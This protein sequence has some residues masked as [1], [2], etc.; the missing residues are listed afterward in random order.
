MQP[1]RVTETARNADS[2]CISPKTGTPAPATKAALKSSPEEKERES[3]REKDISWED[4]VTNCK[5]WWTDAVIRKEI[6]Q[7]TADY[8]SF[9]MPALTAYFSGKTLLTI[10]KTDLIDY[11]TARIKAAKSPVTV[12]HEIKALRRM[13]TMHLARTTAEECPRLSAKA[14]DIGRVDLLK[15]NSKKMRFLTLDEIKLL[16]ESATTPEVRMAALISLNTGLRRA[17]VLGLTWSEVKLSKK[18][19]TL[20]GTVMKSGREH[21]VDIPAHLVPVFKIWRDTN[22]LSKDLFANIPSFRRQWENTVKVCGATFH[23][24]TFH[25]LRHTFASQWL[26]NG[27]DITVL[28]RIMDHSSISITMDV[29]GH[30]SRDHKTKAT[31]QFA[32]AFLSHFG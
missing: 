31:A 2:L 17:N 26:M 23:D 25:S 20:P 22:K 19:I 32:D 28:S 4:A 10:K 16:L 27:G 24:V 8:Y 18:T 14:T 15:K 6:K 3:K 7:S 13:Y 9:N 12:N 29:Y 11:Q 1:A 21:T 5:K 30:L